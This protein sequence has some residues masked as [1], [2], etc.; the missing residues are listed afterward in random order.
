MPQPIQP[1]H[2]GK[3]VPDVVGVIILLKAGALAPGYFHSNEIFQF[4]NKHINAYVKEDF[5]IFSI[6]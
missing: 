2:S 6:T 4:R 3:H 1:I 5:L